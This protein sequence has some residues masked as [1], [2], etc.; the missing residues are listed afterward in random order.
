MECDHT[1]TTDKGSS[2][3]S[4]TPSTNS[5]GRASSPTVNSPTP[6]PH[7]PGSDGGDLHTTNQTS[8]NATSS[9][10]NNVIPDPTPATLKGSDS[11][12]TSA[13]PVPK[14]DPTPTPATSP[15]DASNP[16]Q[17]SA[18]G[19]GEKVVATS[20]QSTTTTPAAVNLVLVGGAVAL[21]A[22]VMVFVVRRVMTR[23]KLAASACTVS[24]AQNSAWSDRTLDSDASSR[25]MYSTCA[26]KDDENM[27]DIT[28][29]SDS[30][31]SS[32]FGSGVYGQQHH[33]TDPRT[34]A[35]FSKYGE[36]AQHGASSQFYTDYTVSAGPEHSA[37]GAVAGAGAATPLYSNKS[38]K[39]MKIG[40]SFVNLTGLTTSTR[41]FEAESTHIEQFPLTVSQLMPKVP[42]GDQEE[43]YGTRRQLESQ[44]RDAAQAPFYH[45]QATQIDLRSNKSNRMFG[46]S[47]ASSTYDIV[48][49]KTM[50][51]VEARST[52]MHAVDN[53]YPKF[54]FSSTTS[55]GI[56]DSD[57]SENESND[58]SRV[59]E[60]VV[61]HMI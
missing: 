40:N 60:H 18:N 32:S 16:T 61:E 29:L 37:A 58:G 2:G 1:S 10:A 24:S 15:P 53:Q 13:T 6:S 52:E 4:E 39:S 57:W 56:F 20:T 49:P 31:A 3:A 21:V 33:P 17:S 26:Y 45:M 50:L 14:P 36:N 9:S 34:T 59:H 12:P 30:Q 23:K 47:T 55:S 54:S 43:G 38:A 44:R 25:N 51:D 19:S 8:L 35:D 48:D 7:T 11:T 22:V 5:R 42:R 28:M 27:K 46:V 41:E